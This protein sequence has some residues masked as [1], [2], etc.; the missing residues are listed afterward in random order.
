MS[1]QSSPR[2]QRTGG[3]GFGPRRLAGYAT[4]HPKRVL[5]IWGLLA[6]IGIGLTSGLLS[7][8]LTTDSG[9]TSKP[10][11]QRAQDL[12]DERLP[13]SDALDEL[14]I[15]RSDQY[16]V[17]D[18]AYAARVKQLAGELRNQPDIRSATTYQ[19]RG[20]AVLVS[21]DGHATLMQVVMTD[22][23]EVT[24]VDDMIAT[25]KRANG[26]G[27]FA[28]HIT[29]A[30]TI[31]RD[32]TRIS[33]SD[34]QQGELQFGL[35]AA[36]IVLVLVFG[37]LVGAAI[38]VMMAILSIVVAMGL[39]AVVG[40][41]FELNIF[42]VNMLVAMGLALGIDYSLFIVSRLREERHHGASTREAILIVAGTATRAVLF[43]GVAFIL[44]MLG[45]FL[46]PDATLRSLAVGAIAVALVSILV[47]LTFHPALLMVL[48]DRV[49]RLRV[50]WIGKRVAESMGE[51]GRFWG[52]AVRAVVRHPGLSASLAC[53]LLLAAAVPVL[54]LKLGASGPQALPDS[55]VGKQG[56]IALE[57]DFPT[58][59]TT[60]V[61]I[62]VDGPS[63]DARV[64][65]AITTLR[66]ELAR[67]P[68]FAA[69]ATTAQRGPQITVLSLPM[70]ADSA[71]K[72][73]TTAIN[74]LRDRAGA[75]FAGSPANV[76]V[77]GIPA[78]NRDYF[79][80]VSSNLPLVIA[81]VLALSFV[82]LTLAF[83]SI[84][85]P[86]TAI[87]VNLLSVGAAYGLLVLVFV[88]GVGGD[89]LG[90]GKVER[91]DAWVPVFLFS[92]LFGLSMDYQVFLLSRIR[93][94]YVQT[95]S[96][97]DG[98]IHGVS[99]TARLITGAALII[100]VV[101][102]GFATGEL[103]G[104][105]QMGFGVAIALLVDATIVRTVVIPAV[106]QL[107]GDRNW[108]LPRWLEWLPNV[109]VEGQ[110]AAAAPTVTQFDAAGYAADVNGE[111]TPT[112]DAAN[113]ADKD[114][115]TTA[116]PAALD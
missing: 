85:V 99:S 72:Q 16:T 46:M 94:R 33:E 73:A 50:P 102:T 9:A 60:P 10:E 28:V 19:D 86:L 29:G 98:I 25:V 69:R 75:A 97:T 84:V 90:F 21:R 65:R 93:E 79:A 67:D 101:F 83:R 107:L 17:R 56:L 53:A 71:S 2:E 38:P 32:F 54:G 47:A 31:D 43:S 48:G 80:M 14:V 1:T 96:T 109:N 66:G 23:P 7:S 35:P 20:G 116:K 59:A 52:G 82:L 5:A 8:A 106:M 113:D 112:P 42:V 100:V 81:F 51:E 104:F 68:D 3:R 11:S 103:V 30:N 41:A 95:G 40:Q 74:R 6:L 34:L 37:T 111:Q 63:G 55:T 62:V 57:R 4:A 22:E 36:L 49:D 26:P 64:Q 78:E 15:V 39:V 87:A 89:V 70:T 76:L 44:A 27:G 24:S 110:A 45:M 18:A 58:G 88:H 91:I 13:G 108:Y 77:G 92:V 12:I 115:K 114:R 105:Q 61:K